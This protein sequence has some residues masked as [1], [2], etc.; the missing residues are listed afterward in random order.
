MKKELKRITKWKRLSGRVKFVLN[1]LSHYTFRQHLIHK[2]NEY[3]CQINVVTEEY[4]SETCTNCGQLSDSYSN[5]VKTCEYCNYKI[6]RDYGGSRNI[7]I[8]NY[9]DV[10]P[11]ASTCQKN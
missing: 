7:L 6:N 9:K 10:S 5:R 4:T 2:A 11:L 3:G 8:K 1:M